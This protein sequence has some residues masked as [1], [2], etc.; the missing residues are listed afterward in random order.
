AK[1]SV[2]YEQP[3]VQAHQKHIVQS[4]TSS[5]LSKLIKNIL[6]SRIQAATCP[7]SSKTYFTQKESFS[8]H[9]KPKLSNIS[10][11]GIKSLQE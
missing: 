9:L 7:S 2:V 5:H 10:I 8:V 4:Y 6:Y 11:V 1:I 3:P